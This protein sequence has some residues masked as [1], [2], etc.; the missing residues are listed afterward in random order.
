MLKPRV[1][2]HVE[3]K[4]ALQKEHHDRRSQVREFDIGQSVM[5]ENVRGEP[6]WL[7]GIVLEKAG[8][9]SY[10]VQVG[11]G[12]WHR[13][14]DQMRNAHEQMESVETNSDRLDTGI[15]DT[16]TTTPSNVE[17]VLPSQ[18]QQPDTG[19]PCDANPVTEGI[20]PIVSESVS[21]EQPPNQPPPPRYPRREHVPPDRLSHKF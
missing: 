8:A 2:D 1:N 15:P 3:K 4:Q 17:D 19:S 9:V 13:H 20:P 6:K 5:V 21:S 18:A 14:A 7:P 10:R 12:V 11:E 16:T